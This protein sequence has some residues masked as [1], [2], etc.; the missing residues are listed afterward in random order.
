[1]MPLLFSHY[2]SGFVSA[3]GD[4]SPCRV[5]LFQGCFGI[6]RRHGFDLLAIGFSIGW[7]APRRPMRI[8]PLLSTASWFGR[9]E[10]PPPHRRSFATDG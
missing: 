10:P 5:S 7:H 8:P 3:P 4:D 9:P 1:M 2:E 6:W